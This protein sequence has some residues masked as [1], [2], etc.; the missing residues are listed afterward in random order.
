VLNNAGNIEYYLKSTN[1]NLKANDQPANID[2]TGGLADG[3][4]VV[5]IP[6]FYYYHH[7][8]DSVHT[9]K[10]SQDELP[11]YTKFSKSYVGAYPAAIYD[12]SAGVY[13]GDDADIANTVND[14]LCSIS[15]IKPH[16]NETRAEYR[17]LAENRGT[18]WHLLDNRT[19]QAIQI[20]YL[21]EYA[22][23]N[24]QSEISEGNTKFTAWDYDADIGP[25]GKSNSDGNFSGGQSTTNGDSLDYMSYRGIED[26]FGNIWQ[27]VDGVNINND[28]SSSKLY[29]C[30]VDSNYADD[31]STNYTLYGNLCEVDGY[32]TNFMDI[33]NGFYPTSIGGSSSTYVCDYYY[34]A[35]DSDPSGGWRVY[36]LGGAANSGGAEGVFCVFADFG[37]SYSG[38]A[39]GAR[40]CFTP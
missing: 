19:L 20:L 9:W 14:T 21:V 16:T 23:L 10:I 3:Q 7:Y 17:T 5:E 32:Q 36:L 2:T 28:G 18:G 24:I 31:I 22:N 11:G 33:S 37:S 12:L 27:F 1:S 25:T 15:G 26:I 38:S 8:A 13:K 29:L 40:L 30:S 39:A 35:Y 6:T 34:T 4:V